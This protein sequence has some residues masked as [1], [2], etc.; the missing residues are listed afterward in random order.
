MQPL[1]EPCLAKRNESSRWQNLLSSANDIIAHLNRNVSENDRD[2]VAWIETM[3]KAE[4]RRKRI[5]GVK[6]RAKALIFAWF[7]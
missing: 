3:G 7:I 6:S 1:V 4:R 2:G 5:H